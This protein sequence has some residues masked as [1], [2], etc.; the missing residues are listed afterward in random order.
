MDVN[1]CVK[2][3]TIV[4]VVAG[5]LSWDLAASAKEE[6]GWVAAL[7]GE[8]D[9]LRAGETRRVSLSAGDAVFLGDHVRTLTASKMK[10]L[11]RDDSVLTLAAETEMTLDEQVVPEGTG[12]ESYISLLVGTVRALV[13]E[14]YG[15]PGARFEMETPTAVAAV[16]GTQFIASH[17]TGLDETVVVGLTDI[18]TVRSKTDSTGEHKVLLGAGETTRIGR[19][20]YPLAPTRMPDDVLR[21]LTSATA[22]TS[23]ST[24]GAP[25]GRPSGAGAPQRSQGLKADQDVIDQPVEQLRQ[26]QGGLERGRPAPPPP[27]I[28]R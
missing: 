1:R 19:G 2:R 8:A 13:S 15:E 4:V 3:I 27:P 11:L 7:E 5:V 17:D 20:A 23:A 10:L 25:G 12:G 14:R 21:S 18:T 24:T 16:R 6:V 26:V 28:S 9:A 22:L